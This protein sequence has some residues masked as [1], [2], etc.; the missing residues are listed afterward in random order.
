MVVR[1]MYAGSPANLADLGLT[2][3]KTTKQTAEEK[4]ETAEKRAA[5]RKARN[6]MGP[7]EAEGSYQLR[8][9][10]LRMRVRIAS[11]LLEWPYVAT[12]DHM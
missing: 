7:N 10:G 3:R 2:P 4:A 12:R 1:G 11:S 8:L 9:G 5:T 6:T